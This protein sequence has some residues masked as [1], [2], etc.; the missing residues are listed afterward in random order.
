MIPRAKVR[1]GSSVAVTSIGPASG[2]HPSSSSAPGEPVSYIKT[3]EFNKALKEAF[4]SGGQSQKISN[5]VRAVLGTLD[6]PNPFIGLPVTNHGE[7]RIEHC[8][9]YDLGDGWRLVTQQTDK[10]CTFLF[11]GDHADTERWLDAH[12]GESVGIRGRTLVRLPGVSFDAARLRPRPDDQDDRPLIDLL[13]PDS[14][15]HLLDGIPRTVAR[16]LEDLSGAGG[17]HV[18]EA[19][20]QQIPDEA[21]AGLVR[22]VLTL[23]GSG[24]VDGAQAHIDRSRGAIV[25][26]EELASAEMISL[27]DG[28]EVRQVRVGSPEYQTWL[29]DFEKRS[30]WQDWFLFLHPQQDKVVRACPDRARPAWW[31]G[32]PCA[33]PKPAPPAC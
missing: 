14:Q 29:R 4:L 17:L 23:L 26:I 5:K 15:D 6:E 10:T 28:D 1:G 3:K 7:T 11:V 31:C 9:K 19:L 12:R 33:S 18:L 8:V 16:K 27:E 21:K 13:P 2:A 30:S 25:P 24:N 32:A 22:T 20:V